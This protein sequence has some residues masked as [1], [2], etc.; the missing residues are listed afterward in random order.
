MSGKVIAHAII[1]AKPEHID[2]V[3]QGQSRPPPSSLFQD[4]PIENAPTQSTEKL[5]QCQQSS[6]SAMIELR[7][8]ANEKEPGTLVYRVSVNKEDKNKL[9]VFEEVRGYEDFGF[10]V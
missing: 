1:Y 5:T 8:F 7:D 2:E 10:Y 6:P 4:H 3:K 9:E